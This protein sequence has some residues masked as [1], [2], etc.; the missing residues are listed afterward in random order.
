MDTQ[1]ILAIAVKIW[2][3]LGP[4][5]SEATYHN[6][7]EVELRASR[8]QYET[9]RII[10]I[11]YDGHTIGNVRADLIID[12]KVVVELKSVA[13]L[14]EAHRHQVN[15]YMTHGPF[16]TGILINFPTNTGKIEYNTFGSF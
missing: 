8:A 2:S 5:F 4:G 6:A 15:I 12:K 16:D 13:K 9:E 10:P 1:S 11:V 3:E 14:N 7:F